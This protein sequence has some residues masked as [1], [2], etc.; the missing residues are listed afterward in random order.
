MKEQNI[1]AFI[2]ITQY[3]VN[4][5]ICFKS[6]CYLPPR[7]PQKP[8]QCS[9]PFYIIR[10][11][12]SRHVCRSVDSLLLTDCMRECMHEH[13]CRAGG[14]QGGSCVIT[15]WEDTSLHFVK[16]VPDGMAEC[17]KGNGP[18]K[19]LLYIGYT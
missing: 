18:A 15:H 4:L 7:L 6:T 14:V 11:T 5:I 13:C 1:Y 19:F 17:V 16:K 12:S 10:T 9:G 3:M 8:S 2:T